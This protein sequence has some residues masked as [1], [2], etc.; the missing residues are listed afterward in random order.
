MLT[1]RSL[2]DRLRTQ[3]ESIEKIIE[4]VPAERLQKQPQ[5]GKWSIK[6]QVAH[7][8]KYQPVFMNRI[9]RIQNGEEPVFEP[10]NA[11]N[12]A[13][14]PQWQS[15]DMSTLLEKL[16]ADR[17]RI[18]IMVNE[19]SCTQSGKTGTHKK[20]GTMN[21]VQWTE[22]F[23]LHESHHIYSIFQLSNDTSL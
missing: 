3:H 19:L 13:E 23:L 2:Q 11:D 10:Y 16:H 22:F 6:D 21:L 7:L 12:D 1:Y 5:P 18:N 4:N 20:F 14:F 15:W 8:A 17:E 9:H